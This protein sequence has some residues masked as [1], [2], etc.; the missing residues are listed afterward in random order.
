MTGRGPHGPGSASALSL[1][2]STPRPNRS[3]WQLGCPCLSVPPRRF[4]DASASASLRTRNGTP[5]PPPHASRDPA[6][7]DKRPVTARCPVTPQACHCLVSF[8]SP[9]GLS[10]M[11]SGLELQGL[12]LLS[13]MLRLADVSGPTGYSFLFM[14]IQYKRLVVAWQG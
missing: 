7:Y 9:P 14:E 3:L 8:L 12:L 2:R 10:G 11:K 13:N 4:P 5:H 1:T 6:H